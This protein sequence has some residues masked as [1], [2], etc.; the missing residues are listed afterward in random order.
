M[1]KL[2]DFEKVFTNIPELLK[3]LPVT[4]ELAL[5]AMII[6]LVL[7]LILAIIK[8]KQIPVLKQIAAIFVSIVRGT[9]VLVQLY[10]VYFGVPMFFKY[11]NQKYG[12]NLAVANIPGFVYAVLALG[13]NSSAFSSEMIRSARSGTCTWNDLWTDT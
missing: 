4:L 12:T 9:P 5:L 7:G 6:G 10:I 3:K 1:A 11:L 8:I 13:L 2:F